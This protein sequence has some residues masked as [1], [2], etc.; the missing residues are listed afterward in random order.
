MGKLL[1]GGITPA[2][3]SFLYVLQVYRQFL[4]GGEQ[5]VSCLWK[6]FDKYRD[7]HRVLKERIHLSKADG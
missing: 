4:S 2:L 3:N 7:L 6:D 5:I 1:F